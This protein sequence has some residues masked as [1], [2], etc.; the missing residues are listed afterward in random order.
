[1]PDPGPR[2]PSPPRAV[3]LDPVLYHCL[4]R[5]AQAAGMSRARLARLL[6]AQG[7]RS[8]LPDGQRLDTDALGRMVR[9]AAEYAARIAREETDESR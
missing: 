3:R 1:M 7:L 6:L 8:L 5:A 9:D 2:K 4:G